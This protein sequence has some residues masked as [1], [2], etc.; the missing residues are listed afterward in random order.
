MGII[1]R[2]SKE[3]KPKYVH[4]E[5]PKFVYRA[6]AGGTIVSQLVKTKEEAAVAYNKI[7]GAHAGDFAL[8]NKI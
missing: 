6:V 3:K 1:K 5:Y 4:Q 8:I 7:A 2:E